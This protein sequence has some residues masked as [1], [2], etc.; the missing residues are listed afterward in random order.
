M[1]LLRSEDPLQSFLHTTHPVSW[2]LLTARWLM[3]ATHGRSVAVR[4]HRPGRRCRRH[5]EARRNQASLITSEHL[6]KEAHSQSKQASIQSEANN[7]IQPLTQSLRGHQN[8][9]P[10]Y[11]DEFSTCANCYS[12]LPYNDAGNRRST[13]EA[14]NATPVPSAKGRSHTFSPKNAVSTGASEPMQ[15]RRNAAVSTTS[16]IHPKTQFWVLQDQSNS[17]PTPAR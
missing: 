6:V 2:F 10:L 12:D 15:A 17:L 9:N 7:N 13:E 4:C 14:G 1:S 3:A 16:L 5:S 8:C 11:G